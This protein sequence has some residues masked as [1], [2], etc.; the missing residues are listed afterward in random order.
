MFRSHL[1]AS[2]QHLL[3]NKLFTSINILS[4]ILGITACF[5]VVLTISEELGYD[6]FHK[7]LDKIYL[8]NFK[9]VNQ[10]R[11]HGGSPALLGPQLSEMAPEIEEYVRF[12][13]MQTEIIQSQVFR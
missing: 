8:L 10:V 6:R 5:L 13:G 7:N 11:Y 2:I 4:L 9:Y 3:K 12:A 1:K